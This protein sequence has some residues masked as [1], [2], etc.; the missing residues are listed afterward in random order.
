M[1]RKEKLLIGLLALT[2]LI[3]ASACAGKEAQ[4]VPEENSAAEQSREAPAPETGEGQEQEAAESGEGQEQEAS[5]AHFTAED[6]DGNEVDQSIFSG[7]KL[8]MINIWATFCGPCINEMPE[9]GELSEEYAD[10]GVQIVGIV[11]DT[12]DS[13]GNY[14]DGQ[15]QLARQIV[16]Q[17]GANYRH[18]LPSEDLIEAKLQEVTVVPTTFFVD[19]DGNQVDSSFSGAK[20]KEDWSAVIDKML[21]KVS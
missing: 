11:I 1:K 6:L 17:T 18:L 15:V 7:C 14:D 10:K 3:S 8:T 4:A 20:S 13:D 12:L 19:S 2:V 21:A 16:E 9:L 5:F